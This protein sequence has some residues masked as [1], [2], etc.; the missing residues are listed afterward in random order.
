MCEFTDQR[1]GLYRVGGTTANFVLFENQ[2][3]ITITFYFEHSTNWQDAGGRWLRHN[4]FVMELKEECERLKVSY[5]MPMQPLEGQGR[6]DYSD[7]PDDMGRRR[8]YGNEGLHMRQGYH[9]EDDDSAAT[10]MTP[11]GPSRDSTMPPG[12]R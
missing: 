10:I 7:D 9:Q 12:S 5:T 4:T 6:Y 8:G 2:N 1:P 3:R 11:A